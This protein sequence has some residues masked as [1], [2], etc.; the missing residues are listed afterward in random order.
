[1][2]GGKEGPSLSLSS[3]YRTSRIPLTIAAECGRAA[4]AGFL[5]AG[6]TGPFR[7]LDRKRPKQLEYSG[8][9]CVSTLTYL[10]LENH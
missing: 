8:G 10:L 9:A 6:L 3:L 1:M 5:S 4:A 2:E 7:R